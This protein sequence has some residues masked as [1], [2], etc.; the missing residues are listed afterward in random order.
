[1]TQYQIVILF[2][3]AVIALSIGLFSQFLRLVDRIRARR[4]RNERAPALIVR[5]SQLSNHAASRSQEA[6]AALVVTMA[7]IKEAT[8]ADSSVR[9]QATPMLSGRSSSA[10][11]PP[12]TAIK[13]Q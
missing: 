9:T 1:M 3:I 5:D 8:A 2:W 11:R 12:L 10:P 4:A 7:A 6:A 13:P